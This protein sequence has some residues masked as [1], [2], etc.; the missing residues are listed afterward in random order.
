MSNRFDS[1]GSFSGTFARPTAT[2]AT[3]PNPYQPPAAATAPVAGLANPVADGDSKGGKKASKDAA[4]KVE[5]E[6]NRLGISPLAIGLMLGLALIAYNIYTAT[7]D[8]SWSTSTSKGEIREYKRMIR[9][10]DLPGR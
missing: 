6:G 3:N 2:S 10:M 7:R 1:S 8:G 5:F 9:P 4:P